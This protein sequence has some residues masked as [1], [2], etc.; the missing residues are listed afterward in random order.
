MLKIAEFEKKS[1]QVN[2]NYFEK[3]DNFEEEFEDLKDVVKTSPIK[4]IDIKIDE[5]YIK[6]NEEFGINSLEGKDTNFSED[7]AEF[8][9]R[10]KK[11][12]N[13]LANIQIPGFTKMWKS[14]SNAFN[15]I[16]IKSEDVFRIGKFP[17]ITKHA[18]KEKTKTKGILDQKKKTVSDPIKYGGSN[19]KRIGENIFEKINIEESD[20]D[21]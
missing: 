12:E 18:S 6:T 4:E 15:E 14:H 2:E 5:D 7:E 19:E 13:D 16:E 21:S 8:K 20:S 11:L 17:N 10:V 9:Q 3:A 1:I